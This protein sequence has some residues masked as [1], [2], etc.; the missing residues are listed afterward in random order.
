MKD[1]QTIIAVNPR[2]NSSASE[3]V[4]SDF[5]NIGSNKIS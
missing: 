3:T 4:G 1:N 2:K 5:K